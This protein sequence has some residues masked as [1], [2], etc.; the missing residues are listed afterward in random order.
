M[1]EGVGG[2][3]VSSRGRCVKHNFFQ[4]NAAQTPPLDQLKNFDQEI[5]VGMYVS[6]SGIIYFLLTDLYLNTHL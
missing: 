3:I 4:N 1:A 2:E 6:I 5:L